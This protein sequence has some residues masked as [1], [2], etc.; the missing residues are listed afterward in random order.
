MCV[1]YHPYI[2]APVTDICQLYWFLNAQT[3][4]LPSLRASDMSELLSV[5]GSSIFALIA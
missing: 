1:Y 5:D 3:H 2:Q 4:I